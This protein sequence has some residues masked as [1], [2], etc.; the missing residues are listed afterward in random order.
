MDFG[1][2]ED[3]TLFQEALRGY[4]A[5]H[6]PMTRVR[7]LMEGRSGHDPALV[8][9]LAAQGVTGVVVPE[10]LGGAG[11]DMLSAAVAAEELG[12]A[13]TPYSFHSAAVHG[14]ARARARGNGRATTGVAAA[15]R[16]RP[17]AARLRDRAH[18]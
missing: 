1:L 12:R 7:A 10:E 3:Q 9:A 6:V 8:E 2:S 13:A 16:R 14:A 4:L 11:L 5:E 17:R 18:R 15:R